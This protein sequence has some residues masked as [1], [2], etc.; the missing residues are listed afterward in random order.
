MR[1]CTLNYCQIDQHGNTAIGARWWEFYNNTFY[2]PPN[3]NQSNYFALRAGSGVVFNN[4]VSG[5]P[6][7]GSGQIELYSDDPPT[8]T[9]QLHEAELS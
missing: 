4:H 7:I 2:V 1:Y 6:N 8:L 3:G 9:Q 5:G